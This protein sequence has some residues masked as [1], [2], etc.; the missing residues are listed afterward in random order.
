MCMWWEGGC[1]S[2]ILGSI[3]AGTPFSL[4]LARSFSWQPQLLLHIVPE[5][6]VLNRLSPPPHPASKASPYPP[7]NHPSQLPLVH[8]RRCFLAPPPPP[9]HLAGDGEPALLLLLPHH[10]QLH[11]IPPLPH[12]TELP[13]REFPALIVQTQFLILLNKTCV[14]TSLLDLESYLT[15]SPRL[16]QPQRSAASLCTAAGRPPRRPGT[17]CALLHFG[18]ACPQCPSPP[19]P[20]EPGRM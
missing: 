10:L 16:H 11:H 19:A 5:T 12:P 17:F 14:R 13:E 4:A 2:S 7:P 8:P 20:A 18:R 9:L 1:S 6:R 3:T 15:I